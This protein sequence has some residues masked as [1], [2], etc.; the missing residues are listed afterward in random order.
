[1]ADITYTAKATE[2]RAS[3]GAVV[4]KGDANNLRV[5]GVGDIILGAVASGTTHKM[6]TIPT[7]ARIAS[8]SRI[9]WDD[10]STTGSPTL[11][12]GL[13]SVNA[14]ITSDPDAL[15]DTLDAATAT[16]T[17]APLLKAISDTGKPAWEI[18]GAS[19]D[20][21]GALDVYVSV[22]DAATAGITT[23]HVVVE[24]LGY[25]D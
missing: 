2:R 16:I 6:C 21:G 12:V 7:N 13:A 20:P 4:G 19:T 8:Q 15:T 18:A 23:G 5:L 25:L 3:P 10:L 24:V 22:V 11:D 9:Y 14:N 17:G 1:M